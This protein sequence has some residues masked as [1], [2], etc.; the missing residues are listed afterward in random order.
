MGWALGAVGRP[1]SDVPSG[2]TLREC[3]CPWAV[4]H[5]TVARP[6]SG[7]LSSAAWEWSGWAGPCAEILLLCLS[8]PAPPTR[9]QVPT[10]VGQ[11]RCRLRLSLGVCVSGAQRLRPVT[12]VDRP[13]PAPESAQ[14]L[15]LGGVASLDSEGWHRWAP[16]PSEAETLPC[17]SWQLPVPSGLSS[18]LALGSPLGRRPQA[19]WLSVGAVTHSGREARPSSTS[20]SRVFL[21]CG[22]AY[23]VC[24]ELVA[25]GDREPSKASLSPTGEA[26]RPAWRRR[27]CS[28]GPFWSLLS[29][30]LRPLPHNR[31]SSPF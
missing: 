16:V 20:V 17:P 30:Q 22:W 4:C 1:G 25:P 11:G 15:G 21:G 28:L 29:I 31:P 27:Y 14:P 8:P 7:R 13:Q 18:H 9:V 3:W 12:A 19:L 23:G 2:V 26:W 24:Q 10:W 5:D 6:I